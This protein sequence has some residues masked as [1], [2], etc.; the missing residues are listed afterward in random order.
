MRY[1]LDTDHI[2]FL[3]RRSSPQFA[4]LNSRMGREAEDVAVSIVSLHEQLL[5]AHPFIAR[6]KGGVDVVLGY[7]LLGEILEAFSQSIVLPDDAAAMSTFDRLRTQGVRLDTMDLRIA[8]ITLS[9]GLV[10]LTRN[11][12]D[13]AKVPGLSTEDRTA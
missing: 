10:L 4:A 3:Q 2:G 1:L 13:F 9:Q 7:R 11:A 12:S 8:S 6:A 5:G